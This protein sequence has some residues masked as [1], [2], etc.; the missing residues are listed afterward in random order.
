MSIPKGSHRA[1]IDNETRR[2]NKTNRRF[3]I[4]AIISPLQFAKLTK[5]ASILYT[6]DVY[7][8]HCPYTIM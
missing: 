4:F 1:E 5:V 2:I 8:S 6:V 3:A 7:Y